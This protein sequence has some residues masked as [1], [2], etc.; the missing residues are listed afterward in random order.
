MLKLRR[1]SCFSAC[2]L[3]FIQVCFLA[4]PSHAEGL[5]NDEPNIISES[6]VLMDAQTGTVLYAQNA[7]KEQFPASITKIVT[8]IVALENESAL[9]SLVTVSK[10]ARGEDGTRIYLA[11]GE[12]VTLEK[13]LYGMLMNSGNDAATAIAEYMDGTKAKFAERMNAWVKE[14]AGAEHTHFVNPS[15]LPDKTQV[16][17]ARDMAN[18][19]RYAMQNEKFRQIVAT[20]RMPWVG[21]EWTSTLINH[22]ELLKDYEG[23]TG[24]KNGY[25]E[26][27]G[28]TLVA[29]AKRDG[30]ELIGVLL[31]SPSKA[32]VYKDMRNLLDYG[33]ASYELQQVISSDQAYPFMSEEPAHF[34]AREPIWAVLRKGDIPSV[35]VTED[36]D[37]M[38]TSSLGTVKAGTME[39]VKPTVE[40]VIAE[41]PEMTA[42]IASTAVAK[43]ADAST[44]PTR[45]QKL[46]IFFVWMGLLVY[47]AILAYIRLKRQQQEHGR[48]L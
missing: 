31:K 24:I 35:G 9:S 46:S 6:A 39:P 11:E 42:D 19:A 16:T 29:S 28:F 21:K 38:V 47:L 27:S 3:L 4:S 15:G 40:S 34:I 33:F 48:G 26:A 7:D 25:T 18:I 17:T 5:T 8:G 22:N 37:V 14:K 12:Q 36:G 20:K 41:S 10:E 44:E 32:V 23:A 45:G 2:L 1:T 30:M 13:L 43:S